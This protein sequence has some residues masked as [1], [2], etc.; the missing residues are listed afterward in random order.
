MNRTTAEA[1]EQC[2]WNVGADLLYH[3]IPIPNVVA[4][5]SDRVLFQATADALRALNRA[6]R[7]GAFRRWPFVQAHGVTAKYGWREN[8]PRYSMK[9]VLHKKNALGIRV[10][11]V[12][13]DPYNPDYGLVPTIGRFI[14]WLWRGK[15]DPWSVERG[16]QKRGVL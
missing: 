1:I 14:A 16:L 6:T 7:R 12:G 8:V 10:L 3:Q 2:Y 13:Y 5:L 4:K 15:T 9:I 11:E